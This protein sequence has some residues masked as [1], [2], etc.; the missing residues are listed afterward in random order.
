LPKEGGPAEQARHFKLLVKSEFIF[1]LKELFE[2]ARGDLGRQI[3]ASLRRLRFM[4]YSAIHPF[5][6]QLQQI[7]AYYREI[8]KEQQ[9]GEKADKGLSEIFDRW[10][11]DIAAYEKLGGEFRAS[12][13]RCFLI[14][15]G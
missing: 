2:A 10:R 4:T 15:A 8:V 7:A 6:E 13:K 12:M 1:M 11:A 5:I 14:S 3:E 9:P